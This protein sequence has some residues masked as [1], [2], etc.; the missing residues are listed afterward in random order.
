MARA[1]SHGLDRHVLEHVLKP[2]FWILALLLGIVWLAT[3]L[4]EHAAS[5]A[6]QSRTPRPED[7]AL[8]AQSSESAPH[9][10]K[11]ERRNASS[12]ASFPESLAKKQPTLTRKFSDAVCFRINRV[13]LT[14]FYFTVLIAALLESYWLLTTL[15]RG[16]IKMF[17]TWLS[18]NRPVW[19][20]GV[21]TM[22]LGAQVMVDWAFCILIVAIVAPFL[23]CVLELIVCTYPATSGATIAGGL[24]E[25]GESYEGPGGNKSKAS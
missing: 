22:G 20:D 12:T 1:A 11:E 13:I 9:L 25:K 15:Y 6:F 10:D 18:G 7:S 14:V 4:P 8:I 19:A 24:K 5:N 2:R 3:V 21:G 17:R 16:T 23:I